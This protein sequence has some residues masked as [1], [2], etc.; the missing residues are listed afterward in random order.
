MAR[1]HEDLSSSTERLQAELAAWQGRCEGMEAELQANRQHSMQLE[2]DLK[3]RPTFQ[4]VGG[5]SC[6]SCIIVITTQHQPAVVCVLQSA[7]AQ[8]TVWHTCKDCLWCVICGSYF[9]C[10]Q[11]GPCFSGVCS[12]ASVSTIYAVPMLLL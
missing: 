2:Q 5:C 11:P 6:A 8:Q 3:A 7:W 12:Q 4:Q 1:L 10:Q 9:E